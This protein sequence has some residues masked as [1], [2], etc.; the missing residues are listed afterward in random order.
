METETQRSRPE[1][2][3]LALPRVPLLRSPLRSLACDVT[4]ALIRP[5]P[6]SLAG[7]VCTRSD[8]RALWHYFRRRT[9]PQT[10]WPQ[11]ESRH[12]L[13]RRIPLPTCRIR[14]VPPASP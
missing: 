10:I 5:E 11:S 4:F 9:S 13:K 12:F 14:F 6:A 2:S 1:H 3:L 7:S 8:A